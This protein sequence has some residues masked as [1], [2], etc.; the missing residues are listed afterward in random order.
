M[1]L[2]VTEEGGVKFKCYVSLH[3]RRGVGKRQKMPIRNFGWPL[4]RKY[5]RKKRLHL[6]MIYI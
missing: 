4:K 2:Y 6:C 1:I 5:C 3:R